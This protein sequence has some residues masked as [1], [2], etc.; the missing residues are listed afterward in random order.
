MI[1]RFLLKSQRLE[2]WV[3][4]VSLSNR[5]QAGLSRANSS[6]RNESRYAEKI[7][8]R[9][10][11][12]SKR[13]LPQPVIDIQRLTDQ[14]VRQIDERIVAHRERSGRVF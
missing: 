9:M 10:T 1:E 6:I 12:I 3:T 5:Q 8:E 7:D 11:E 4:P 14:V 13:L 2:T